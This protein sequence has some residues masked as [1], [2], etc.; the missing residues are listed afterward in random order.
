MKSPEKILVIDDERAVAA[1]I[2]GI[3]DDPKFSLEQRV[4]T[5][6]DEANRSGG[7]D[8]ISVIL[9]EVIDEGRWERIKR[10]LKL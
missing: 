1:S 7:K 9:M 10:K 5:L 2:K 6:I 4:D 3:L 8:N